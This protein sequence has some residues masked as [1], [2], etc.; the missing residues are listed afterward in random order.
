VLEPARLD[1]GAIPVLAQRLERSLLAF[2]RQ[3]SAPDSQWVLL[4]VEQHTSLARFYAC[5]RERHVGIVTEREP[6]LPSREV[7]AKRPRRAFAGLLTQVQPVA[8]AEEHRFTGPM[9]SLYRQCRESSACHFAPSFLGRLQIAG[10][11]AQTTLFVE[12]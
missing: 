11:N 6:M 8:V 12:W 4:L 5:L 9:S 2:L 7:I 3:G 10:G 1:L